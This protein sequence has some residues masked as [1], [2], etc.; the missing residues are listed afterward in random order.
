MTID[1]V[2]DFVMVACYLGLAPPR[3]EFPLFFNSIQIGYNPDTD[4]AVIAAAPQQTETGYL[5]K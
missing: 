1:S 4:T 3:G 5:E 2:T